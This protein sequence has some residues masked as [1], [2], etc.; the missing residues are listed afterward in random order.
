MSHDNGITHLGEE[1]KTRIK[2]ERDQAIT[3]KL[4]EICDAMG[5][6]D[7]ETKVFRKEA[8]RRTAEKAY[9]DELNSE[10]EPLIRD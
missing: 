2:T 5:G 8:A 9:L 6:E 3:D 1:A 10:F 4:N 7:P